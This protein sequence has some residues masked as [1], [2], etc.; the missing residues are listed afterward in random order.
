MQVRRQVCV[1]KHTVAS[2]KSNSA[3]IAIHNTANAERQVQL[4]KV[5]SG[6]KTQFRVR[7]H[8]L[9]NEKGAHLGSTH[10]VIQTGCENQRNPNAPKY[11]E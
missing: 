3:T 10:E 5:Q 9:A 4:Q 7:H 11:G 8:D 6:D 1:H 2:E